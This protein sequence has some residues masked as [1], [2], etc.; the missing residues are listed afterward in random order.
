MQIILQPID[1]I[2]APDRI[3]TCDPCLRSAEQAGRLWLKRQNPE[4]NDTVL[5]AGFLF[6]FLFFLN[7]GYGRYPGVSGRIILNEPR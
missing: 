4:S 1:L 6:I 5:R 2:G 7:T 3:R